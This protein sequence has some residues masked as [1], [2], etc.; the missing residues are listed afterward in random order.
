M[1]GNKETKM[2]K[3]LRRGSI[4]ENVGITL[5]VILGS[6]VKFMYSHKHFP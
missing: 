1:G 3:K 4:M 5:L 6:G 2:S